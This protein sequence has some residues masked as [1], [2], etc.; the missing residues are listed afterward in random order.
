[1]SAATVL[2]PAEVITKGSSR[3]LSR[4]VAYFGWESSGAVPRH[5]TKM[6]SGG[7]FYRTCG[8]SL[9]ADPIGTIVGRQLIRRRMKNGI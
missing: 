3:E 7:S 2:Q 9:G 6:S 5:G 1:M 4:T 8:C